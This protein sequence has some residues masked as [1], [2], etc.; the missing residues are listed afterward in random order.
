MADNNGKQNVKVE[1]FLT[2]IGLIDEKL[3]KTEICG[4]RIAERPGMTRVTEDTESA[5]AEEMNEYEGK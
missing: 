5:T 1:T 2:F 4:G 3:E